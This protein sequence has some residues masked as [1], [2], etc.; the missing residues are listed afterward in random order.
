MKLNQIFRV[1]TFYTLLFFLNACSVSDSPPLEPSI[2]SFTASSKTIVAGETIR[3]SASFING[4]GGIN[5]AVG[6]IV[7]GESKEV[8][9]SSTTTYTLTVSNSDGVAVTQSITVVVLQP[10]INRF[11]ASEFTII[12]GQSVYLKAQFSNGTGS[13]DNGL[14]AIN[15]GVTIKVS[16]SSTID[17]T[18]TV[19]N[20]KGIYVSETVTI[21]V[22]PLKLEI[23]TPNKNQTIGERLLITA[24]L[25]SE[26][27]I[28]EVSATVSGLTTNL[29]HSSGLF[30]GEMSLKG[31]LA[32]EYKLVVKAVDIRGRSVSKEHSINLDNPP[33]LN[34]FEP[35]EY[36]VFDS[37]VS[38]N[39]SCEDDIGDCEVIIRVGN[40]VLAS[41]VNL[42]DE[43]IDLYSY[44]GQQLLLYIEAIDSSKQKTSKK[45]TIY[46]DYSTNLVRV[47]DFEG[48]IIDFNEQKVLVLNSLDSGDTLKITNVNSEKSY[49]VEVEPNLMISHSHSFLTQTGAIYTSQEIGETVLSS[50][51]FDWNNNQ[52]F[53]LGHPNSAKSLDVSGGYAIWSVGSDLWL[54]DL[55]SKQ[56]TLVSNTAGNWR[57]SVAANGVVGYWSYDNHYSIVKFEDNL[58]STLVADVDYWNTYVLTDGKNFVYQKMQ[59]CCSGVFYASVLFDGIHETYLSDLNQRSLQLN[60]DYSVNNGWIAF[61]DLGNLGQTNIWAR[62]VNGTLTQRTS[63]G[64]NSY[65]ETLA[66]NGDIMF[67][68][69]NE[70]YLSNAQS[71]IH[72]VSSSLGTS[73]YFNNVWYI[74]IGRS[75]FEVNIQ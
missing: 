64:A 10:T 38:P 5:N 39:I 58:N 28:S 67:I 12:S 4:E 61:T 26:L 6:N 55:T 51:I 43:P 60:S 45:R 71:E 22:V 41:G 34:V 8:T 17:Y 11:S 36:S 7:A 48:E 57:N 25:S 59:K 13:I 42:F 75:L 62:D 33:T 49:L 31:V 1:L 21:E 37:S 30:R 15:S 16:P 66:S 44:D 9:P 24:S 29:I 40:K 56:N 73:F 54:R 74:A 70:R 2:Q 46:V 47:K 3:L 19:L 65:I 20:S 50:K 23:I 14:G 27:D 35:I 32:G 69:G 72:K 53:D 68:Y 63:Y 52:L 18:L